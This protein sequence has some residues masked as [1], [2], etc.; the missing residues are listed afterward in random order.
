MSEK[1]ALLCEG[2]GTKI[3][4]TAGVLQCFLDNQV[5]FDYCGGISAGAEVLLPFVAKQINRLEF[6]AINVASDPHVLGL[7]PFIHERGLFGIRYVYEA[8]EKHSPLDTKT[9][10]ASPTQLDIGCY[11]MDTNEVEYFNK[12]QFNGDVIISACSL[13]LIN[14]PTK[15][16]GNRYLDAGLVD[17]I[18]I[19]Q[20]IKQGNDKHIFISTKEESFKRKPASWWQI[21]LAR[22]MYPRTKG[23]AKC[24]KERHLRYEE[25]WDKV[26][27]L[28]ANGQALVLRP[29]EDYGITRYTTDQEKLTKWYQLGYQDTLERLE[30]I[31]A[32]MKK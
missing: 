7:Y 31:R 32:F 8:I 11:N 6:S 28:E 14:R 19:M 25:Q 1:I 3:A 17:M 13:F 18:P 27:E 23:I 16:K 30:T 10:Y 12:E 9:F 21:F 2:G 29:S 26:K 22:L 4:Y 15:M 5:T 24:L 20:S